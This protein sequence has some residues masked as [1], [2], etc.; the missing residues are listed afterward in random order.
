[1]KRRRFLATILPI[2]SGV[3][4][5]CLGNSP[6]CTDED[7]W[8]PAINVEE[9]EIAPD[10]FDVF[11]I[12]VNGITGFGFDN[13]LYQCGPTDAPV[14]FGDVETSPAIDYQVDSC[15][16]TWV[17]EDCTS[18]TVSTPVHVAPDATPGEYEYGFQIMEDIEEQHSQEYE[19]TITVTEE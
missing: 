14:R 9:L 10:G 1:M 12:Q 6:S 18:V 5:G 19:Y 3:I 7:R 11:D 17:W 16:P 13:R 2:M 15:P 4:G 8:P